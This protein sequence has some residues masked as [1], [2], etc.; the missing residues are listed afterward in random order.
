MARQAQYG[1]RWLTALLMLA[2]LAAP[3]LLVGC[4]APQ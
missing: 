2:A 3:L 4:A 1:G